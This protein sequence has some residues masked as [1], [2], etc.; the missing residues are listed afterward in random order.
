MA[1]PR[2]TRTTEATVADLRDEFLDRCRAKNLSGEDAGVV[3]RPHLPVHRLVSRAR[4]PP[5]EGPHGRRPRG[6]RPVTPSRTLQAAD[7]PGLCAGR[8]DSRSLRAPEGAHPQRPDERLRDAE[9]PEDHHRNVLGPTARSTPRSARPTAVEGTSGPRDPP[10]PP[11]HHG[12]CFR[13][14][15]LRRFRCRPRKQEPPRDGQGQK[16]APSSTRKDG[17]TRSAALLQ[18]RRRLAARARRIDEGSGERPRTRGRP[19]RTRPREGQLPDEAPTHARDLR[20]PSSGPRAFR[21]SRIARFVQGGG[22]CRQ[23]VITQTM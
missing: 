15:G 7:G 11:G 5:G 13:A 21:V 9:G 10:H 6:L 16:G 1:R 12:S 18:C 4:D 8:E 20:A 14:L 23:W 3:R 22:S 19:P 17:D 2:T